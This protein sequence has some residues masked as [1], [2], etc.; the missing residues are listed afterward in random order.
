MREFLHNYNLISVWS[1]FNVDFTYSNHQTTRNG[2]NILTTSIDH[3]FVQPN[4]LGDI[5]EA[6][7]I[8]LGDNRSNHAPFFVN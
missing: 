8:H 4:I 5:S 2:N 1:S 3:F 6:Q 7:A